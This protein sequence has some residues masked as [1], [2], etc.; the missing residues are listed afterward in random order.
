MERSAWETREGRGQHSLEEH[1]CTLTRGTPGTKRPATQGSWS[2]LHP[3]HHASFSCCVEIAKDTSQTVAFQ[4]QRHDMGTLGK[5]KEEASSSP[6]T[7]QGKGFRR[8]VPF[9]SPI[10]RSSKPL[11]TYLSPPLLKL[12]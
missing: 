5:R 7:Q 10:E 9:S 3:K 6:T 11:H 2:G 8:W 12:L 1:R 4:T